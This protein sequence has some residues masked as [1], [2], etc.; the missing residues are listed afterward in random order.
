V[1]AVALVLALAASAT[2]ADVLLGS[3]TEDKISV[4][5]NKK[6]ANPASHSIKFGAKS[7]GI[8]FT[9]GSGS[10]DDPVTNG[11]AAL[12][13]SDTDCQCIV[14]GQ[15]PGTSPGW[16]TSPTSGTPKAYKWKD[17]ATRSTALVKTGTLKLKRKSGITYGLD[18]T[19]QGEVEV[20]LRLGSSP[21]VLCARFAAPAKPTEDAA[22]LYKAKVFDSGTTSCS[23]VPGSC[24]PCEPTTSTTTTTTST[25]TTTTLPCGAFV[26]A[27]GG[28]GSGD[29][30]LFIP[31][32]VAVDSA[33]S[34]FVADTYNHRIQK[35]D[36]DGT[37]LLKWGSEGYA[38]G[39][40]IYPSGIDADGSGNVWVADTN[41]HRIA[42]FDG[43]GNYLATYGLGQLTFP[44][45]VVVAPN[46]D[47]YVADT[48]NDRVVKYDPGGS[49]ITTWGG[50]GFGD[51]QFNFPMSITLDA[52]GNVYVSD[53]GLGRV[54]K[55]DA[56][57][58]FLAKWG[59][60]AIG[61]SE[62]FGPEGIAVDDAGRVFVADVSNHRV[63]VFTLAGSFITTW[64]SYGT[65]DG[66]FVHPRGVA[67]DGAGSVYVVDTW[68]GI[69]S[70]QMAQKFGCP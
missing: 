67:V 70:H 40:F 27:W 52:A 36:A 35:F 46:G 47:F 53:V 26:T 3:G 50:S 13:F 2:A 60:S 45:D 31:Y 14:L 64:G 34:V 38:N 7:P 57:G 24:A 49:I 6:S 1:P 58:G 29:G 10:I 8:V 22:T 32:D 55:F 63:A 23:M 69:L 18:A 41:R 37:F 33:G 68:D 39:Q 30:Q 54:Q 56:S 61:P 28:S 11:A 62:T 4:Q 43:S 12:V 15:A 66:K 44:D 21:D 5:I 9:P 65:T 42:K 48:G 25:T 19:P 16:T 59:A 17:L 20:Q 51:G